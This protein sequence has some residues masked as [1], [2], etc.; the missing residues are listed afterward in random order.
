MTVYSEVKDANGVWN[1]GYVEIEPE[2]TLA[3]RSMAIE[4]FLDGGVF[5]TEIEYNGCF[6]E[7]EDLFS[8]MELVFLK[9]VEEYASETLWESLSVS[10]IF[11]ALDVFARQRSNSPKE[12]KAQGVAA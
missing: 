6:F 7:A 1:P 5:P 8:S 9:Y 11:H 3:L 12:A 4:E 2:E 10:K